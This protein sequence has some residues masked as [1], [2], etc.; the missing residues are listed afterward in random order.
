MTTEAPK[1]YLGVII[2]VG[3]IVHH[4]VRHGDIAVLTTSKVRETRDGKV[5]IEK[6]ISRYSWIKR[7]L[8]KP[9]KGVLQYPNRAIV[10]I[11]ERRL[12]KALEAGTTAGL[13]S[14]MA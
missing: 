3:D 7:P 6:S 2:E 13:T 11:Q 8:D 1:D 10:D 14:D 9:W 12:R 5:M 4:A